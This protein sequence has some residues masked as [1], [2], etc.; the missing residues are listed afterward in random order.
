MEEG[1]SGVYCARPSRILGAD[2]RRLP[3]PHPAGAS[4]RLC[5]N[6]N[7]RSALSGTADRRRAAALELED[8]R[9]G[10]GRARA[11][12]FL[13]PEPIES[14]SHR[15]KVSS[16]EIR[17]RPGPALSAKRVGAAKCVSIDGGFLSPICRRSQERW[18]RLARG[19]FPGRVGPP[20][21]PNFQQPQTRLGAAVSTDRRRVSRRRLGHPRST[22]CLPIR[23]VAQ[24]GAARYPIRRVIR[25]WA[26]GLPI[27]SPP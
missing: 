3:E 2:F 9:N 12:A 17:Y 1:S 14:I 4:N 11:R 27:R 19:L 6:R 25:R 13:P 24:I 15:R 22:S 21:P 8:G 5:L 16:A 18:S 10:R 23:R 7:P 26:G 20:P